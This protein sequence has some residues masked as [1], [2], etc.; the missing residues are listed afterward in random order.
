MPKAT[1]ATHATRPVRPAPTKAQ[2]IAAT[3]DVLWRTIFGTAEPTTALGRVIVCDAAAARLAE[4]GLLDLDPR[5][6]P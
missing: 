6:T 3:S 5:E 4:L 1:S 2:R